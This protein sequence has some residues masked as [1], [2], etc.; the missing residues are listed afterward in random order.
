MT[1]PPMPPPDRMDASGRE[2]VAQSDAYAEAGLTPAVGVASTNESTPQLS[3]VCMD[4]VARE[5]ASR[6]RHHDHGVESRLFVPKRHRDWHRRR[7]S[8]Y[9]YGANR[10]LC[11]AKVPMLPAQEHPLTAEQQWRFERQ[12]RYTGYRRDPLDE[13]LDGRE[14]IGYFGNATG[15]DTTGY[16]PIARSN[17]V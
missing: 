11:F 2:S 15:S 10:R 7:S 14:I 9:R 16:V 5:G 17:A 3:P 8:P 12:S 1:A 13:D 4:T 6:H